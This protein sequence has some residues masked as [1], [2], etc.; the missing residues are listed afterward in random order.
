MK[1]ILLVGITLCSFAMTDNSQAEEPLSKDAQPGQ[2]VVHVP[3]S[4]ACS[5]CYLPIPTSEKKCGCLEDETRD[6]C[7]NRLGELAKKEPDPE[8]TKP[9]GPCIKG[10]DPAD[11]PGTGTCERRTSWRSDWPEISISCS[12]DCCYKLHLNCSYDC[13]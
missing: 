11:G 1:R 6:Q 12:S 13:R 2:S 9:K 8:C 3:H 4:S 7:E 5:D 10:S